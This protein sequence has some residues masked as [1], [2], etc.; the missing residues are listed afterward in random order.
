MVEKPDWKGKGGLFGDLIRD[1]AR[2]VGW[3]Q[4]MED[5]YK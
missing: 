1:V 3:F 4:I 5:L 2:E